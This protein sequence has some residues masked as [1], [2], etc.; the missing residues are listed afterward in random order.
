[1]SIVLDPIVMPDTLEP[2]IVAAVVAVDVIAVVAPLI[3]RVAPVNMPV[4]ACKVDA[5]VKA[6]AVLSVVPDDVIAN[7]AFVCPIVIGVTPVPTAAMF[8]CPVV[9]P[10]PIPIFPVVVFAYNEGLIPVAADADIESI[11]GVVI[12]GDAEIN[13]VP[14]VAG[15]VIVPVTP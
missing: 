7:V 1:M 9:R 15:N 5:N 3:A 10:A 12:V 2:N 13:K 4:V 14:V 6:P 11:I 8:N